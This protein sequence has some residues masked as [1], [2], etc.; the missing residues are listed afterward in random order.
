[1]SIRG[2]V[3]SPAIGEGKKNVTLTDIKDSAL[4]MFM[5]VKDKGKM[6]L[7]TTSRFEVAIHSS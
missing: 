6:V 5:C 2:K 4:E 3:R 7:I 1:M